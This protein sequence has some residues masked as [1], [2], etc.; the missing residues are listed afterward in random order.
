[1]LDT[2]HIPG[3]PL[4]PVHHA[5]EGLHPRL[6]PPNACSRLVT[7]KDWT[8]CKRWAKATS[9]FMVM[10]RVHRLLVL[11]PWNGKIMVMAML[12]KCLELVYTCSQFGSS[13][14]RIWPLSWLTFHSSFLSFKFFVTFQHVFSRFSMSHQLMKDVFY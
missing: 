3:Q 14:T 8:P 1:M 10:Y 4:P 7:L 11:V 2:P 12:S 9:L 13:Y 6:S 5:Y